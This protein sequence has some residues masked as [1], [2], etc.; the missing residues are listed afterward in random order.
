MVRDDIMSPVDA[1]AFLKKRRLRRNLYQKD[2]AEKLGIPNVNQLTFYEN[3]KTDWRF[4]KYAL[5]FIQLFNITADEARELGI[6]TIVVSS[7]SYQKQVK[8]LGIQTETLEPGPRIP[9]LGVVQAVD[10][11]FDAYNAKQLTKTK[12]IEVPK[13][14]IAGYKS[15]YCFALTVNGD[16]M[17]CEDA[18][19]TIPEGFTAA[20]H[21]VKEG[22][23]Q[24]R[25]G[26][27]VVAW[28]ADYPGTEDGLGVL[29][30]F[31]GEG[32]R[33]DDIVL[34][35]YN[36][37]GQRFK[38]SQYRMEIQGIFIGCWLAGRRG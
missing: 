26:D 12:K 32:A 24:P 31:K 21:S 28:I 30:V 11:K 20:F 25:K 27:V 7:P 23:V 2:V 16:S 15:E 29:K 37:E 4:G 38:A 35:S 33:E 22:N 8:S 19:K 1:G 13:D 36:R 3:G 18:R 5:G 6:E 34:D 9:F 17:V 10:H 14:I